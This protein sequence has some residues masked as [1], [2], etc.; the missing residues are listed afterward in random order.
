MQTMIDQ[1]ITLAQQFGDLLTHRDYET[2]W[3]L[4]S[5]SLQRQYSAQTL[6]QTVEEMISYGSSPIQK[7][8]V[9]ADCLLTQ[10]QYPPH[11][12]Q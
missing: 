8:K 4:L 5:P 12:N 10:W 6:G 2:A 11:G 1:A 7:A 3:V 9:M